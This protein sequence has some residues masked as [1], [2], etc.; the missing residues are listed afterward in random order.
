VKGV[1]AARCASCHVAPGLPAAVT[2]MGLALTATSDNA[3][4]NTVRARVNLTTPS[5]SVL[6][7]KA[8]GQQGHLGGAVLTTGSADYGV[9]MD[10]ISQ[11]ARFEGTAPPPPP[12][13]L[14]YVTNIRPL[15]MDCLS[16]H[17]NATNFRL[18]NNLSLN[19]ADHAEVLQEVNT[20]APATS[21]LLRK[22]TNAVTHGGGQRF[23]QGSTNYNTILTW[24][25]Q[26]ARLQ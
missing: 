10:W 24:I 6:L 12:A 7:Q 25:Q 14:T 5:V 1:L 11:G 19:Q 15:L 16:C 13:Q 3:D 18:S 2:A 8:I 4:Y 26:G 17:N 20:G 9:L 22:A 21:N 23:A